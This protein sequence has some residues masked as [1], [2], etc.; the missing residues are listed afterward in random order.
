MKTALLSLFVATN[1]LAQTVVPWRAQTLSIPSAQAGDPALTSSLIIGTDTAQQGLYLF[2]L[3]GSSA[4]N[5]PVGIVNSVDVRGSLVVATS[6][7][8]GI[9]LYRTVPGAGLTPETPSNIV[10]STPGQIALGT[11]A[12]GGLLMSFNAGNLLRQYALSRDGGALVATALTDR[13][14]PGVPSGL[15]F[16]DATERLYAAIPT[17]GVV[18]VEPDGGIVTAIPFNGGLLGGTLGGIDLFRVSNDLFIFTTAPAEGT[19]FVSALTSNGY[20]SAGALKFR[21]PDAGTFVQLPQ[22]LAVADAL[23]GYPDGALLVHDGVMANYKLVSM[24]DIVTHLSADGGVGRDGGS[25][26]GRDAG[27][28]AASGGGGAISPG[29]S[30]KPDDLGCST[31][32]L[33]TLPALLLL[34]WIRRPRS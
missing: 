11:L 1:V 21:A 14:L 5:R 17:E 28:G 26:I 16:D 27:S 7:A 2:N 13:Q 20:A 4:G 12:D 33:V 24:A 18:I 19:V 32:A 22:H 9:L 3:D 10:A 30:A 6:P 15:A 8:G 34:W 31:G 29:P 23:T 25:V